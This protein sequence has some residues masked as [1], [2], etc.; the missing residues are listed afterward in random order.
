M[1]SCSAAASTYWLD[2][3]DGLLVDASG[4]VRTIETRQGMQIAALELPIRGWI[5]R[6]TLLQSARGVSWKSYTASTSKKVMRVKSVIE[7][8]EKR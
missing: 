3:G 4:F 6:D 1:S 2:T 5:D 7:T 8:G